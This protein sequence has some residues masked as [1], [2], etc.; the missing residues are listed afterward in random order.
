M[1]GQLK[2]CRLESGTPKVGSP[3]QASPLSPRCTMNGALPLYRDLGSLFDASTLQDAP[4]FDSGG[5]WLLR[6]P[7]AGV[8]LPRSEYVQLEA[9]VPQKSGLERL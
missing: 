4:H 2:Q 6:G 3:G 9:I 8:S 5:R 7:G 1:K